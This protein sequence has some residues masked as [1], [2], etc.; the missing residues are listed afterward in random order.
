MPTVGYWFLIFG[1][2]LSPSLTDLRLAGLRKSFISLQPIAKSNV[3]FWKDLRKVI[4]VHVDGNAR[5]ALEF[6]LGIGAY[7]LE[8]DHI[9][10]MA[11]AV[12]V[13]S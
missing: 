8:L 6:R 5:E 12:T 11:N 1:G 3:T 13:A 4:V 10:R 7:N 2:S 9:R